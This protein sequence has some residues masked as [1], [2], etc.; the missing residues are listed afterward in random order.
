MIPDLDEHAGEHFTFRQLCE[1]G[2]TWERVRID[3]SPLEPGTYEAMRRLTTDLLDPLTRALGRP[4]LTHGFAGAALNKSVKAGVEPGIDQHG[5]HDLIKSGELICPRLGQ[6]VDLHIP[7]RTSSEVGA[8]IVE[9][10]P[11]DRLYFYGDDRPLH[12]SVGPS[13][14][15]VITVMKPRQDGRLYPSRA[16]LTYFDGA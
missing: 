5:G 9:N 6:A 15:K 3:N 12:V 7:G 1:V 2:K 11:F 10:T 14:L 8:F 4:T 16:K 13:N